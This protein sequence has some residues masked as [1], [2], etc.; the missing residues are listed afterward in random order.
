M[1]RICSVLAVIAALA[2]GPAS[3]QEAADKSAADLVKQLDAESFADRQAAGEE[4]VK[5]GKS[6]IEALIEGTRSESAET[7]TRS[8]DILRRQSESKEP[9]IKSAALEALQKL[10]SGEGPVA[11]RAAELLKP[12]VA[13]PA[14]T[15]PAVP[16]VPLPA[17]PAIR[18]FGFG[19][20]GIRIAA[21]AGDGVKRVSVKDENGVKDIEVVEGDRTIKINDDPAKG[22]KVKVT[23]KKDGKEETK[24][25]EAKSADDLKTKHSEAHK[26][27]EQYKNGGALVRLEFFPGLPAG[28]GPVPAPPVPAIIRRPA[29]IPDAKEATDRLDKA[30]QQLDEAAAQLK[31]AAG[32]DNAAEIKAAL[33]AI[34][35][36]KKELEAVRAKLP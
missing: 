10:S 20:G 4:L 13:S 8:L 22:I 35:Q 34:E 27:Y 33:E 16:G 9:E 17:V 31:K 26:L 25:Y 18:G 36:S 7:V 6:A 2:L 11:R 5:R 23:E 24:E 21:A 29:I 32:A 15:P 30:R 12:K 28:I 1:W 3:A 14:V 19:G